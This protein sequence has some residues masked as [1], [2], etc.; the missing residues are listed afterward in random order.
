MAV[1]EHAARRVAQTQEVLNALKVPPHS[2][3]A[4]QAVLGGLMLDN[5]AWDRVADRVG[6]GDFYRNDHRLI[7]SAIAR[8]AEHNKPFDVVTL[9]ES[10]ANMNEL[11]D[12]GGLAYLGEL[13]KNTPSAANIQ[14][15]A[16]IVRERSVLRQLIS[17]TTEIAGSAFNTE[18][19]TTADLLDEAERKIFN[20]ADQ[21]TRDGGP[22]G[23]KSLLTDA[24][25]RVDELYKSGDTITGLST[26]YRDL[27][28]MTSG[29]QRGDL[30]IVAGRPSMGK[31]S[32]AMNMAEHAAIK[33]NKPVLV[34]SMEMPGESLAMRMMSSLGRI[35]Q[36][37]IRSG[38][39]N[40]DDWPRITSAV[41]MLSETQLFIDDS[42][43][44]SPTEVR[45]RARRVARE[46]GE[47]GAIVVDYL[48][49]MQV[50][51]LSDNRVA[52]I[53]Q[54]SQSLKQLAKELSTP[55]IALSQ[56][57]RSL[58]QRPNKRP[59]MSDLR[60]CV[61]GD[62]LVCLSDGQRVPIADLVGKTPD[63][64]TMTADGKISNALSDKVWKVGQREVFSIRLT[65][66]R[67]I[68]A[69]SEHRLFGA[70]GWKTVSEYKVG[71]RLALAHYLPEPMVP[72]EWP[73]KKVA[74]LGQ[75]IGDGSYLKGQPMRFTSQSKENLKIVAE[76]VEKEFGG[77]VNYHDVKGDC[78]QIVISGNGNRWHPKGANKWLRDLGIFNQRSHEKRIPSAAFKLADRQVALLLQHLWAT[79]GTIYSRK[80]ESKGSHAIHYSTNSQGL[81]SDVA[82]LLL[83]FGIVARIKVAQKENYLPGYMVTITGAK[84][85]R[86][87]LSEIHAFG[88]RVPQAVALFKILIDVKPNTNIDTL[89][90]ELFA[91]VREG[92]KEKG[93]SHRQMAKL[94]GTS[95]G[96]TSHFSFAPSRELMSEYADLLG[97][98]TLKKE[99]END[100][101]WDQIVSIEPAGEEDVYDLTVPETASW[102]ADGIVSHNSGAIEQDADLITFIYRDE[103]YNEDSPDKGTAEI[104]IAKQRN[105]PIGM[106]R[107]TFIGKYTRFE[108]FVPT[109]IPQGMAPPGGE[110]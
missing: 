48:Q 102:L 90:V 55:V 42:S 69:T 21:N 29:L 12:A 106:V 87:F 60:E 62:T 30:I 1:V 64:L 39:L 65:S 17:V 95:Y 19:R 68:R 34:F 82:A 93:I 94:R 63:V 61:T 53:S 85:Q 73:D 101:F 108:N 22:T 49:L 33:S 92:M 26:G 37:R 31:T 25:D 59:V 8:L 36:S 47:L 3:E 23:I 109:Q 89:P 88:P 83:R 103:V 54:I 105:G 45:A 74:F 4:E 75:M 2:N 70:N 43:A 80:A 96:G 52:E 66:G 14:A 40:D 28:E 57:N 98:K 9:S 58:E 44:L 15:Y 86:K 78:K 38:R 11:E 5:Q 107:L 71:D 13:A 56:L 46:H 79:D 76:A 91:Q 99:C 51:G 24:L 81:A 18:G 20:I 10:L 67:Y 110:M 77:E 27:D 32:F 104:I 100:L 41:G 16:D 97:D 50:P 35:D 84:D 7:F 6:E 72:E